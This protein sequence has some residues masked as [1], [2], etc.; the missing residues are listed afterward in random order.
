MW[1]KENWKNFNFSFQIPGET[2]LPL[3][4]QLLRPWNCFLSFIENRV[5]TH[6]ELGLGILDYTAVTTAIQNS[7]KKGRNCRFTDNERYDI[8]RYATI[9]GQ[10]AGVEKFKKSH[11]HLEFGESTARSLRKKYHEKLNLSEHFTVIANSKLVV[12]SCL[13]LWMKKCDTFSWL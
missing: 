6:E 7:S 10:R 12:H 2:R 3:N 11:P 9:H 5:P 4:K 13:G 8:G 1:R